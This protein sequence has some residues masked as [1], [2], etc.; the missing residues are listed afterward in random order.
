MTPRLRILRGLI[1]PLVALTGLSAPAADFRLANA[2]EQKDKTA[3]R[4]LLK[5]RIGVDVPQPDGTTALTWAAHWDDLEIADLLVAAGANANIANDFGSTPLWEACNN[6]SG[7]MVEK[8]LKAGASA[9]AVMLGTGETVL[10]RCARTG[11]ADAVKALIERGAGV[12]A[13]ET[14]G[15][16]TA[17]MWAV[18]QGHP[19]VVQVLIERGADIHAKSKGGYT[20]L[21]FAARKGAVEPGRILVEAGADLN[22]TAP[23]GLNALFVAIDSGQED[24]AIFLAE[25]GAKPNVTD[26]NGL[27]PLHY[28]LRK[29]YTYL[30]GGQ[31]DDHYGDIGLSYLFRDDMERLVVVLLDHGANPNARITK[32]GRRN[33]MHSSDFVKIGIAGAT[34]LMLAAASGNAAMIR[35]LLAK[36]ADPTLTTNDGVTPLMAAAGVGL[37]DDRLPNEAKGAMDAVQLFVEE[38]GADVNATSGDCAWTALHGA[39]YIGANDII[40]YLVGKG[41]RLNVKDENGQTPLSIAEGD[42]NWLSDDHDRKRHPATAALIRRLGGD[43]LADG[44][45]GGTVGG[46]LAYPLVTETTTQ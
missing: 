11:N 23:G 25:R 29:G 17:L 22:E 45:K 8:L 19:Q 10:M 16:Q 39:A 1:V 34:P 30:K 4:N 46:V 7:A 21:L 36:G 9:N 6:G 12:N 33:Q 13:K 27:T 2:A 37:N 24:F 14:T 35:L 44:T 28:A 38:L 15:D 3:V 18:S 5:Q 20:P 32:G 31:R 41:A 40:E 26:R 43:P 42:L